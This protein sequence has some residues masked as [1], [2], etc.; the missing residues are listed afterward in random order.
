MRFGRNSGGLLDGL[1]V[2]DKPRRITSARAVAIVKRLTQGNRGLPGRGGVKVGHAGAL[3]PFATGLLILL[4]GRATRLCEHVMSWPKTYQATVK[5]GATTVTDDIDS[6]E[7]PRAGITSPVPATQ[8]G[9]ALT[10]FVGHVPQRPPVYSAIKI[11]GRRA[12][13]RA[14]AGAA[15]DPA[16]RLVRIDSIDVLDYSWPLLRLQIACGR[17]TYIRALA[18]DLGEKLKTGAY[19]TELRRI[20]IGPFTIDQSVALDHLTME[21]LPEYIQIVLPESREDAQLT[22]KPPALSPPEC[23]AAR[24]NGT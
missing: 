3:D 14:R 5:L 11:A 15:I 19:L 7:Q 22:A 8:I 23:D 2:I 17:G 24:K 10:D 4:L 1:I 9:Q 12:C 20:R 21:N 18:R 16:P 13:D 6:P